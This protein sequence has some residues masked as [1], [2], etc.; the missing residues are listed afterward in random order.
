MSKRKKITKKWD[1][2]RRKI[3]GKKRFVWVRK[4]PKTGMTQV[5]RMLPHI[6]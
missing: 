5:R 2:R 6:D 1:R 3:G 4:H